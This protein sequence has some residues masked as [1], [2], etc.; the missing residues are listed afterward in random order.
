MALVSFKE[1]GLKKPAAGG[2]SGQR[3]NVLTMIVY[4]ALVLIPCQLLA[5]FSLSVR[6]LSGVFLNDFDIRDAKR[7]Q[8]L[9]GR[10]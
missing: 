10:N 2:Q 4:P 9:L 3:V 1:A 6:Q 7:P 5:P 8:G